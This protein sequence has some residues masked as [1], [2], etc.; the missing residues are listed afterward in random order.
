MHGELVNICILESTKQNK[1]GKCYNLIQKIM[2]A[3]DNER[4]LD[5]TCEL[6][7]H[8]LRTKYISLATVFGQMKKSE[9]KNSIKSISKRQ[10]KVERCSSMN[11]LVLS[12]NLPL[13]EMDIILHWADQLC[14]VNSY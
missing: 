14:P 8:S 9:K 4:M 7:I 1:S 6:L 12:A 11:D 2:E 10:R 3:L 13:T 5:K